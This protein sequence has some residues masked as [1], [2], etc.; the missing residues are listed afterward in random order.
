MVHSLLSP[1]FA[2][3]SAS[4]G[5]SFLRI[6]YLRVAYEFAFELIEKYNLGSGRK[7]WMRR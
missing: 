4:P 3:E 5:L 7:E 2:V 1:G 6:N